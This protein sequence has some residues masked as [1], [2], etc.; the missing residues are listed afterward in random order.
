MPQKMPSKIMQN[1]KKSVKRYFYSAKKGKKQQFYS[2]NY[3][4]AVKKYVKAIKNLHKS[5]KKAV[6]KSVYKLKVW[7]ESKDFF[8]SL[9][10]NVEK[11]LLL[12]YTLGVYK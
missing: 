6:K 1:F 9:L 11:I 8:S 2:K 7:C 3:I 4:K 12:C 10:K 5:N